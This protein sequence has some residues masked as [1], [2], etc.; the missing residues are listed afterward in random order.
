MGSAPAD[1]SLVLGRVALGAGRLEEALA[2]LDRTVQLDPTIA[3]AWAA[4]AEVL[5]QR[6]ETALAERAAAQAR[7]LGAP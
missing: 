1:A 3:D 4:L 6:G 2:L 7:R 5:H